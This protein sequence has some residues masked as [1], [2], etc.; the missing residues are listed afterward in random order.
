[1]MA[2]KFDF[3]KFFI[4]S[5]FTLICSAINFAG[6]KFAAVVHIPLYL[7]SILTISV[8]ALY[9]FVPGIICAVLSNMAMVVFMGS[10]PLFTFCHL[11]TAF[12]HGLHFGILIKNIQT[13]TVSWM[14]FCGQDFLLQFQMQF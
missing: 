1:M 10:S 14:P 9:G 11:T 8:V 13:K 4:A 6:A 12:L 7:D 3:K 2:E 5:A